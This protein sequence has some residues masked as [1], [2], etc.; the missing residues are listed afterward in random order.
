[1]LQVFR[2]FRAEKGGDMRKINTAQPLDA[3]LA[4]DNGRPHPRQSGVPEG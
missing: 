4:N 3:R 1:V 2:L